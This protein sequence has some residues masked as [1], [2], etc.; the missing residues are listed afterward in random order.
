MWLRSCRLLGAFV[1]DSIYA[2]G[3]VAGL[4][5]AA[6]LGATSTLQMIAEQYNTSQSQVG[7]PG[8]V[9]TDTLLEWAIKQGGALAVLLV[10]L[11]FY[12]RDYRGVTDFWRDQNKIT[13]DLLIASTKAQTEMANAIM[14]NNQV[15]SQAKHVMQYY[16]P[17]QR[18]SD[19]VRI[20]ATG[21]VIPPGA[22]SFPPD[23]ST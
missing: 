8:V 4:G 23:G 6:Y 1:A 21:V 3:G 15:I 19:R 2:M 18:D 12:R 5:V 7:G 16:L 20:T 17:Q 22:G 9:P 13:A 10:V 11:F 14:Q